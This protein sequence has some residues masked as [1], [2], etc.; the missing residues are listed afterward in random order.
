[1]G[2]DERALDGNAAG[3]VLRAIFGVE[4]TTATVTCAGCW[5]SGALAELRVYASA[6][7]TVARCRGCDAALIR[8]AEVR[9][10]YWIDLRGARTV[11]VPAAGSG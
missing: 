1:M 10:E 7:G 2:V 11:R 6:M 3:G 8:V 4:M 5:A 9:G